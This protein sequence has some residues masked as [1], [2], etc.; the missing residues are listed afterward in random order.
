MEKLKKKTSCCALRL[1]LR[2]SIFTLLL[3]V[4][5]CSLGGPLREDVKANNYKVATLSQ[6][7]TPVVEKADADKAWV[8]SKTGAIVSLRSLC[9]RYEHISLKNLSQNLQTVMEDL[10]VIRADTRKV[11]SRDAYDSIS[12]GK[13][14]GVPV[15]SR[16]IVLRKDH[17][18]FDFVA[19]EHPKLSGASMT[20]VEALVDS[21]EFGGGR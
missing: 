7:W 19:T 4:G 16:I 2:L 14:D 11:A 6:P 18:I 21:F 17:C 13:L 8:H 12:R 9:N 3:S 1:S 20:A 10:E 5:A 15:E